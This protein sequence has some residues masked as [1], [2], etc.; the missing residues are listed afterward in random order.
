MKSHL[1]SWKVFAKR[2]LKVCVEYKQEIR[3]IPKIVSSFANTLGGIFIIGVEVD[4]KTNMA[5]S[6]IKGIPKESGIEE[7]IQRSAS[8][9][10]YPAVLPDVK[11]VDIP[12]TNNVVVVVRVDESVQA[13]HAIQN[14]T[15]IYVR[16][17]STTPPYEFA[18]VDRIVYMLKRRED[19]QVVA[20]QIINRMEERIQVLHATEKPTLTVIAKPVF[21]YRPVIS[22]SDISALRLEGGGEPRKV[23]GGV[24][25]FNIDDTSIYREFNEYGIVCY[26]TEL[27]EDELEQAIEYG[28]FLSPIRYL[29]D[30]AEKL[31]TKSKYLGNIEVTAELRDVFGKKLHDTTSS[32]SG[33]SKRITAGLGVE[34]ECIDSTVSTSARCL[35]SDFQ[36]VEKLTDIVEELVLP[37]LWAFNIPA[38]DRWKREQ[39]RKRIK[40][41]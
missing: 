31:Y 3:H 1:K 36:D 26:R 37:L 34:P 41:E 5:I 2:C 6:P 29:I 12:N 7:Q 40:S 14:S 16:E 19:S 30:D 25:Y 13:P 28:R 32:V 9:G 18:D 35:L 17:G 10:I 22:T 8:D 23:A 4:K 21:P 33:K 20:G 15:K 27:V 39:I 38:N 11:I 24:S